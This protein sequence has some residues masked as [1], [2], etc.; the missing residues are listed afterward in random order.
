MADLQPYHRQDRVPLTAGARFIRGFTR[1]GTALALLVT[2]IGVPTAIVVAI[3]NYNDE[4]RD[5]QSAQCIARL[6]RSGYA[7][8]K[9]YSY[10]DALNYNVGGCSATYSL[11]YHSVGEVIA[12]ADKPA[13]TF[14]WIQPDYS[15]LVHAS[16]TARQRPHD[17]DP[18]EHD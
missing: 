7:F 10:G 3:E 4:T 9:R 1:I 13:P 5:Y 17:A 6:A 2:L 8:Q 15:D 18:R 11:S 12:I 16:K 14:P